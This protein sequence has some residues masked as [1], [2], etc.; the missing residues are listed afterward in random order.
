[1]PNI[2]KT[3][4]IRNILI[5]SALLLYTGIVSAQSNITLTRKKNT[6][7]YD[8]IATEENSKIKIN[9]SKKSRTI[10]L[11][12][13]KKSFRLI[14]KK[15]EHNT[16]PEIVGADSLIRFTSR[17]S[18]FHDGIRYFAITFAERSQQGDGSGQC[19]A[20]TEE[21]FIAYK[22]IEK[23]PPKEI[24]RKLIS[25]CKEGIELD[26]GD[27]NNND[28]SVT[29]SKGDVTFRWLTFPGTELYRIGRYNYSLNT[30]TYQDV[31]RTTGSPIKN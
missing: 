25:S 26:Y 21:Y 23:S 19:G 10:W 24:F 20:G 16:N 22:Q 8:E 14:V 6:A 11:E 27:G 12:D 17:E 3:Q 9:Y 2:S 7:T 4:R 31:D 29:S 1:M 13:S 18:Y 30:I 5:F 15:L 28:F